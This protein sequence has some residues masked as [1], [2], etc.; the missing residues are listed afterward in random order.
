MGTRGVQRSMELFLQFPFNNVLHRHVAALVT[1]VDVRP[2]GPLTQF[3]LQDCGLLGWL[4]DA[5]FEVRRAACWGQAAGWPCS[6]CA[7]ICSRPSAHAP[8]LL[9]PPPYR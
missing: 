9:P 6:I 3:L 5:P 4:V 7:A 1:A 8:L 2:E